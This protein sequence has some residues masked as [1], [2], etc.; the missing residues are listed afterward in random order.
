MDS[1]ESIKNKIDM[2]HVK[3][4]SNLVEGYFKKEGRSYNPEVIEDIL[5]T[6][7]LEAI[8]NTEI[9]SSEKHKASFP[10]TT[11]NTAEVAK[12]LYEKYSPEN[13]VPE[14][15]SE[16]AQ[17]NSRK[18]YLF[19][20]FQ[21]IEH[22]NQLTFTEEVLHQIMKDLP[23]AISALA[24]GQEPRRN[25]VCVI[26][27]PTTITGKMSEEFIEELKKDSFGTYGSMYAE[28]IE[29]TIPKQSDDNNSTEMLFYGISMGGSFA[30]E[31]AHKVIEDGY[32]TQSR[33]DAK[34]RNIPFLRVRIDTPPG[35]DNNPNFINKIKTF[36]GFALEAAHTLITDPYTRASIMGN[37]KYMEQVNAAIEEKGIT[38][39]MTEEQ[40]R[41]KRQGIRL[42]LDSLAKG[43]PIP[44]DL[45]V[46]EVIGTS[47][48]LTYSKD[49]NEQL[50]KQREEHAGSMAMNRISKSDNI[51]A[52]G[53]DMGHAIPFV[54]RENE[55]RR[56]AGAVQS[57]I[58][59]R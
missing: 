21:L 7:L 57:L 15:V 34:E 2:P 50:S 54:T 37:G 17:A 24:S 46:T 27:S 31:T 28:F 6:F 45:K 20:S 47:D 48:M 4:I 52:Y 3:P 8:K 25:E 44:D 26:G 9:F 30:T 56:M 42:V 58:N 29:S 36:G 39:N 19:G 38:G 43:V 41:M 14:V 59:L 49:F 53:A 40:V 13:Q 33:N 12:I 23:Q 11:V 5:Y 16:S 1:L 10:H 51:T 32:A 18:E 22:G 55:I 35:P